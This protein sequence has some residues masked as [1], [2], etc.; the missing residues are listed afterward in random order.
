MIISSILF[1]KINKYF[2]NIKIKMRFNTDIFLF[3][4]FLVALSLSVYY[5]NKNF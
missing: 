3:L 4:V 1:K 5:L 2:V